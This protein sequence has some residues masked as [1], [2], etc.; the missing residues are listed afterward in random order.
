MAFIIA[1]YVKT[2]C[3]SVE[4][5][6]QRLLPAYGIIN[7]ERVGWA[8]AVLSQDRMEE[9]PGSIGQGAR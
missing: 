2:E 1:C 7:L 3:F 4:S 9:S 6:F 5:L 8:V